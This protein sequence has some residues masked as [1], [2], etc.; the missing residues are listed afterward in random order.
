MPLEEAIQGITAMV[1]AVEALQEI[2]PIYFLVKKRIKEFTKVHNAD[3][4]RW[5][6][7]LVFCLLTAYSSAELGLRCQESLCSGDV[8]IK[9]SFDEIKRCISNE[10]HR[11]ADQRARY[12]YQTRHLAPVIKSLITG[13]KKPKRAREWLKDNI[14]GLGWK[15]SSHFLRNIGY[16]DLAIIDRHILSNLEEYGIIKDSK[17]SLTKR[18]YYEYEKI[19]ERVADSLKM[20]LGE[21]DLYLWYRKTGQILK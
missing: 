9:G 13:F 3:S 17:I 1:E 6:E 2:P 21:L 4:F 20:P 14:K 12:I 7:E 16:L 15:E 10:G 5:Y 11:F 18:R 8:L 19:L